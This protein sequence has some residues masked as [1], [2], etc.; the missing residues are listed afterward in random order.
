VEA[1]ELDFDK[2]SVFTIHGFCARML[3]EYAFESKQVFRAKTVEPDAWNMLVDDAF[4]HAWRL[5]ITTLP[6]DV[7]K[8]LFDE[9]FSMQRVRDLVKGGLN[10]QKILVEGGLFPPVETINDW[11]EWFRLNL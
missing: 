7:L 10:G 2:A 3:A 6:A 8:F 4:Y 5:H 1:A 11:I 9:D